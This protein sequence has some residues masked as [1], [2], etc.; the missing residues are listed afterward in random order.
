[1]SQEMTKT[2]SGQQAAPANVAPEQRLAVRP[3]VDVFEN[4]TEYLVVADMPG[5][6]KDAVEVRFE[7]GELRL[8][9]RRT[10]DAPGTALAEEYRAADFRRAFAMP[11][12]VDAEKIVA[13]LRC[14]VLQVHLPK[15]AAKRPRKIEVRAS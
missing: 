2:P 6:A 5:V 4:E 7:D 9:A 12:G 8:D 11:D 1:M 3:R 10:F 14:G 15:S 13:E